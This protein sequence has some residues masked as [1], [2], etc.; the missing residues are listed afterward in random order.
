MY[1][2]ILTK[3]KKKTKSIYKYFNHNGYDPLKTILTILII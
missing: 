1:L 2:K 3:K